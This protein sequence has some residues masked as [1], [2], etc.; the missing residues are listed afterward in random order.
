MDRGPFKITLIPSGRGA[1]KGEIT[2]EFNQVKHAFLFLLRAVRPF[3][4]K[5]GCLTTSVVR[6]SL[7]QQYLLMN[8]LHVP[9]G[10]VKGKKNRPKLPSAAEFATPLLPN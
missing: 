5:E 4:D 6:S 3:T 7:P 9:A 8:W 2:L 1:G 10:G